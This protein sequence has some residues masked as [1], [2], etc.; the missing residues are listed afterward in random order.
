[1]GDKER[2]VARV[3]MRRVE[4]TLRSIPLLPARI[5][6]NCDYSLIRFRIAFLVDLAQAKYLRSG[7]KSGSMEIISSMTSISISSAH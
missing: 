1:M 5:S 6:S 3:L 7:A 2:Y 4:S